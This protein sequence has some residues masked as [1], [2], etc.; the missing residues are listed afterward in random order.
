MKALALGIVVMLS[1]LLAGCGGRLGTKPRLGEVERLPRLETENPMY[2]KS[3][4]FRRSYIATIEALEKVDL[5]AQVRGQVTTM[6]KAIDIGREVKKKDGPLLTLAI[7]D[8]VAE[9]AN[10]EALW[11]QAKNLLAQAGQAIKVA[12]AETKEAE[13]QTQRYQA[14]VDFRT[15]KFK[16]VSDLAEGNTVAQQLKE[17]AHLELKASQAALEAAKTQVLTKQSRLQ[18]AVEEQKVADSR[19][20][21][22]KTEVDR[23]DALVGFAAVKAPFDGVLTK[24]WVDSGAT[25]KDSSMPLLT[26]Q[27]TDKVRVLI[28]IPERDVPYI[29]MDGPEQKGNAVEIHIPALQEKLGDEKLSGTITLKA[30]AL[31]P[32]TRTM[33]AE[34]HLDNTKGLLKP[35]MTGTAEVVLA[36]RQGFTVPASALVR[37]GNKVEVYYVADPAGDP[38][39]GLVKRIEVQLGLD[40][41]QRV[42]IKS[43]KWKLTGKEW[44]IAK[45]SG[46]IR[47]GDPAVS[48]PLKK[49][50]GP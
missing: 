31:D 3:L 1:F 41:G 37:T 28:D 26:L 11:D 33:R 10:K 18:F 40:D 2:H 48:V 17:E 4:E 36:R 27:S 30:E 6:A 19:V 5:C 9:R 44:I 15:L 13:A 39:R 24:R 34:I 32:V 21:V 35:N 7:P 38:P 43:D 23:L 50:N 14:E 29:T 46:V 25:V 42:E 22:A 8:I 45:G 49:S 20:R 12:A 16:R 47:A